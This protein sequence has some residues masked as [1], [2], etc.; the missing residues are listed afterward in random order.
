VRSTE[1]SACTEPN[2]TDTPARRADAYLAAYERVVAGTAA[3]A[4]AR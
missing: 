4:A 1:S 3:E 2:R